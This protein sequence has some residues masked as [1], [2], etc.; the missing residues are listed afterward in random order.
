MSSRGIAYDPKMNLFAILDH[1]MANYPSRRAINCG[2]QSSTYAEFARRTRNLVNVLQE[3]GIGPGGALAMLHRNCHLMLEA[4]FAAAAAGAFFVPLNTRLSPAEIA[5]I[6]KDSAASVLIAEPLFEDKARA[7]LDEIAP[8]ARPELV[9]SYGP[10][11]DSIDSRIRNRSSRPFG[12][13]FPAG[14]ADPAQLYYTSGTTGVSKGVILTHA[15][16]A[17]HAAAAIENLE[18]TEKDVWLHAAPLFHL[19][20]A[21]ATWAITWTGGCHVIV[22][23]FDEDEV[24]HTIAN[25]GVTI[26]NLIPTMLNRL[27]RHGAADRQKLKSMRRIMSGGA[28]M[29]LELL[30][31]IEELFPCEYV[32][33]YGLTETSPFLTLS[34]PTDSV[35]SLPAAEQQRYRAMTGRPMAGVE[36]KVVDASGRTVPNDGRTVGEIVARGPWVTPG[37][38]KRPDETERAFRDGWFH[39]GDLAHV[40]AEGYLSIVDRIKDVIN[41][42]GEIVYST[43]VENALFAHRAVRDVAVFAVP[44]R[45]WGEAV[46]ASVVLDPAATA[47]RGDLIDFCRDR[48]AAYKV[49][50]RIDFVDELPKTG[51]GKIDKKA[52]REPWWRGREKRIQ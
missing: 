19:A 45:E 12:G 50:S 46:M 21:W 8:A 14:G 37:Y 25:E 20:D 39:T 4:Y 18:I 24:L 42:G 31:K 3:L 29:A 7:A 27:V 5:A 35:R 26:T 48:L 23:E 28:P 30:K 36:V 41:T 40:E 13:D 52:L 22:P 47:H 51:S 1:A 15:N 38:F 43:E 34:L 49:P 16:V 32:Q 10:A 6:V 17:S 9:A 2:A 33:T 11:A 44:D